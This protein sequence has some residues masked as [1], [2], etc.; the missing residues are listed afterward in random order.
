MYT[1]V[2]STRSTQAASS[3]HSATDRANAVPDA[4][5]STLTDSIR[6]FRSL[7]TR[8]IYV[9]LLFA[10]A[11]LSSSVRSIYVLYTHAKVLSKL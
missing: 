9:S 2:T 11:T 3:S 5:V 4:H 8:E 7:I 1:P 10:S 6:K